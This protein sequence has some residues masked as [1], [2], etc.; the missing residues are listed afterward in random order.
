MIACIALAVA[1]SGTGYAVTA[2]PRGSVGTAQI[3]NNAVNSKKVKNGSLLGADFK[4]GQL[5]AGAQGPPGPTGPVGP[6]GDK[7]DT[8]A[9][10]PEGP[11]NPNAISAQNA[12]R[13]DNLD[14]VD[15]L[16]SNGKAADA[17][18]LDGL[19]SAAFAR[20]AGEPWHVV[21]ASGQPNFTDSCWINY[22]FGGTPFNEA[23]FYKDQVGIVHLRGLVSPWCAGRNGA[24]EV[25]FT[26]PAGYRPAEIEV[27][28]TISNNAINRINVRPN[29]E[30]V[31]ELA[32][33]PGSLTWI[34]LDGISFRAAG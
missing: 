1:L 5:P 31:P 11:P 20:A 15:F 29:G 4:A 28:A 18:A 14:S 17:D 2:L 26:L 24:G 13:L 34:S 19:D 21:G 32:I 25:I 16:R 30:V 7:G 8:G 6:Q 10:G 9:Q 3:K 33:G 27:Q 23:G 12:D 22:N